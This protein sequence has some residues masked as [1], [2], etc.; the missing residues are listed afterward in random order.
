MSSE[1]EIV[2]DLARRAAVQNRVEL[3]ADPRTGGSFPVLVTN[4]GAMPLEAVL[5]PYRDRPLLHGNGGP[6]E[7]TTLES[8]IDHARRFAT[9]INSAIF[10]ADTEVVAI[11]DYGTIDKPDWQRHRAKYSLPFSDEWEAWNNAFSKALSVQQFAE[12]LESRIVDVTNGE[13]ALESSKKYA[14]LVGAEFASA[15]RLMELSRG[16]SIRVASKVAQV[17]NLGSGEGAIAYSAEHQDEAGKPLKV[18]GLFLLT[19]PVFRDGTLYQVPVRLRYRHK[20]GVLS[21]TLEPWRLSA[22]KRD[23]IGDI[24][25]TLKAAQICPVYFGEP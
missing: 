19:L 11:Y 14:G 23:A 2:A 4:A 22:V 1:A 5:A 3:V 7:A 15:Q 18:P 24:G 25:K 20:E 13:N 12:L 6:F 21:W 16:L 9:D 10:V 8:F 17:T